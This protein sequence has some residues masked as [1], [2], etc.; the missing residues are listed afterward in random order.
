MKTYLPYFAVIVA[1]LF[2]SS[3][4]IAMKFIF[5]YMGPFTM[6]FLRLL[7]ACIIMPALYYLSPQRDV[8]K[9]KHIPQFML[10]ALFEP[11]IYFIGESCGMQYVSASFGAVIISLIPLITLIFAWFIIKEP[12]T[13]WG[14]IGAVISFLGV[15]VIVLE[16]NELGA[17]LKGMALLFVAV[18]GAVGYGIKLRQIAVEY[19]PVTIVTVQTFFGMLYFLP[20]F[21]LVEG[22]QFF[23]DIPPLTAF[24]PVL[25]LAIFCT[26]GSFL[27]F[28]YALRKIGLNN[29]NIFCNMIPVFTA[30][31]AFI[32]LHEMISLRKLSGIIIVVAGLFI[33]QIPALRRHKSRKMKI[34]SFT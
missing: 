33:S 32:I 5:I 27:L 2:W 29:A 7:I 26:C 25:G 3:S 28:T 1:M 4:F 31:L 12:V 15:V 8:I 18:F 16:T 6:T 11:F 30:I 22:K 13:R 20:V 10:L 17:T 19:E 23:S 34:K 9:P 24:Y 14:I 21:L